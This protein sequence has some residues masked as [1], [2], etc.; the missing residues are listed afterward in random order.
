MHWF[1]VWSIG[2]HGKYDPIG[3]RALDLKHRAFTYKQ[4]VA[5]ARMEDAK[6]N[7]TSGTTFC[8]HYGPMYY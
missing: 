3:I 6:F 8:I 1:T 4:A 7:R 2:D 5:I